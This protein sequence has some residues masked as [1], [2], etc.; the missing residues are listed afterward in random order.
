M[1]QQHDDDGA[2]SVSMNAAQK[3]SGGN[4]FSDVPDRGVRVVGGGDVVEREKN[5]GDDLRNKKKQQAG[6][7][8]VSQL[9]AAG[10]RLIECV[11]QQGVK[12]G[13][14]LVPV[15]EAGDDAVLFFF[16]SFIFAH[17]RPLPP[18]A[19]IVGGK[20]DTES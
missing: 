2:R 1:Q 14:S 6:A 15:N 5:S 19:E 20:I 4:F 12:S 17:A 13:A 7:E 16:G 10:D 18:C 11:M 8:N 3:R 9:R